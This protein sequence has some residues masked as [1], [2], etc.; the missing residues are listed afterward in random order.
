MDHTGMVESVG[1]QLWHLPDTYEWGVPHQHFGVL[2]Q[3]HPAMLLS[4]WPI[5]CPLIFSGSEPH[6][7]LTHGNPV[8]TWKQPGPCQ[9]SVGTQ[10]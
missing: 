5:N 3:L 4:D 10:V 1:G 6:M 9:G 8:H 2:P 7:P